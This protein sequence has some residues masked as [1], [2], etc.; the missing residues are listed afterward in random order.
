MFIVA[1]PYI[2]PQR[3]ETLLSCSD[4]HFTRIDNIRASTDI[5]QL[6]LQSAATDH[7]GRGRRTLTVKLGLPS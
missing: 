1:R 5:Q 3:S 6:H 2:I 4:H 7:A